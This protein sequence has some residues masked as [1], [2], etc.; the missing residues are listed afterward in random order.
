M[1]AHEELI[2]INARLP[3]LVA[4]EDWQA[5]CSRQSM[6]SVNHDADEVEV[7]AVL[8]AGIFCCSVAGEEVEGVVE[9][10]VG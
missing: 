8:E 10:V 2:L 3:V 6:G 9:E 1:A 5:A 7:R 4:N